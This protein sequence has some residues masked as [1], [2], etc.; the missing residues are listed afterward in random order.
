MVLAT[1]TDRPLSAFRRTAWWIDRTAVGVAR[2]A[3]WLALPV[4]LVGWY[5]VAVFGPALFDREAMSIHLRRPILWTVVLSTAAAVFGGWAAY[6]AL[7]AKRF[8]FAHV[9]FVIVG[10]IGGGAFWA[11]LR[12]ATP[13]W[14]NRELRPYT[15]LPLTDDPAARAPEV[16][17]DPPPPAY[18]LTNSWG[19]RDLERKVAKPDGAYRVVFVGDSFLEGGFCSYPVSLLAERKYR[20]PDPVECVNLGISAT[21]P[22]QYYYR[23]RNVGLKL[24]P[25]AVFLFFY[26]GNDFVAPGEVCPHGKPARLDKFAA[27]LPTPSLLGELCPRAN[28]WV[29]DRMRMS[30]FARGNKGVPNEFDDLQRMAQLPVD[31]GVRQ[32]AEHMHR[33][34]HPEHTVEQIAGVLHRGG[35][36]FWAAL[37]KTDKDPEYLQAWIVSNMLRWELGVP[38]YPKSVAEVPENQR[39]PYAAATLTWVEG[40]RSLCD[41]RG[42]PLV[43]FL[44]PVGSVDPVFVE[45]WKPWPAYYSYNLFCTARLAAL[46]GKL[47]ASG[48]RVVDLTDTLAGRPGTYRKT[49]AH[50]NESGHEIVA[51][52]VAREI[53]ALR[54][55]HR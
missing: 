43:V 18:Y 2:R 19:Q 13:P 31:E 5:A 42:I 6:R 24:Q 11:A 50:W 21:E 10:G 34:H 27:E 52:V 32:L 36:P 54:G 46:K 1:P 55:R 14:P 51:D 16:L 25:D 12:M 49:D 20:G 48:F 37:K 39:E 40:I 4:A 53:A 8:V 22:P 15:P 44:A 29:V 26:A 9:L 38:S 45:F 28:W 23:L 35:E 33:H 47:L 7:G 41:E 3:Y 30:K 17:P